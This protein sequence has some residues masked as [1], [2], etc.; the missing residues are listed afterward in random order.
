MKKLYIL[1]ISFFFFSIK[2]NSQSVFSGSANNKKLSLDIIK[3]VRI[4]C[5]NE[6]VAYR[7]VDST[8]VFINPDKTT[9]ILDSMYI[10]P[11]Q[12]QNDPDKK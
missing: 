9:L 8:W 4:Y 7:K 2:S 11:T 5:G 12:K 6:L 3:E 10:R 1:L